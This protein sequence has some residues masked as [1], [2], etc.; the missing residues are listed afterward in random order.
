MCVDIDKISTIRCKVH[1]GYIYIYQCRILAYEYINIMFSYVSTA[2]L[3][4]C[5]VACS[6][7]LYQYRTIPYQYRHNVIHRIVLIVVEFIPFFFLLVLVPVL[8][9]LVLL[10]ECG[11]W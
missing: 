6:S 2:L 3:Y 10:F 7:F 9:F 1:K 8:V 11:R 4:C 5:C